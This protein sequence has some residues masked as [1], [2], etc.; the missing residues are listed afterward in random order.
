MLIHQK[1][2]FYLLSLRFS[3]LHI[4]STFH[5]VLSRALLLLQYHT[6]SSSLRGFAEV[7]A[8]PQGNMY[9]SSVVVQ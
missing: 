1:W 8:K 7:Q 2:Y 4:C 9:A 5:N 6:T 3:F